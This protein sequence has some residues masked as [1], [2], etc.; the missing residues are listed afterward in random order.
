MADRYPL[1]ANP[2]SN[3]IEE[4]AA[5]DNLSL[6]GNSIVGASTITANQFIGNLAGSATTSTFLF[7]GANILSGTINP[8][9]LS[10]FYPIGVSTANVLNNATNILSGTVPRERLSGNYDI[11]ITGT[12]AT[13]NSLTSASN[14]TGGILPS[15]RLSGVYNIDITGTAYQAVGAAASLTINRQ[16]DNQVQFLTYTKNFDSDTS[17]FVNPEGLVYN[18]ALNYVGIGTSIP[19]ANLDVR[20]VLRNVGLTTTNNLFA[21][22]AKIPTLEGVTSIDATTRNTIE[23]SLGLDVLNDL[24]VVGLSTFDDTRVLNQTTLNR[25]NVTGVSTQVT[26]NITN[27]TATRAN[28]TGVTTVSSVSVG[29]TQ[30][31]SSARQLQNLTGIDSTTAAS[32]RADLGLNA[33]TSIN[34][35]GLSTFQDV[36]VAGITS[37]T[38]VNVSGGATFQTINAAT[39]LGSGSQLSGIVTTIIPGIG[40]TITPGNGK[41][42]VRIDA[43]KPIGK[44]IFVT[45]NGNDSNSGLTE[46]DSK[47]SIKAAAAIALPGDT[48]KVFPGYY[49]ENN[50]IILGKNVAVEGAELR[51]CQVRPLN[52]DKDLFHVNNAVHITDLSFVGPDS[53]NGAAVVAFQPLVGV[54]SNRFFDA[55]RL[56]RMNLDYIAGEAVGYLTSTAYKSPAFVVPTGNARDCSDDIKDIFKAI[57]YDITRGGNSKSVGAAKTYFNNTG[58]LQH[59]TGT[60]VNGYSVRQATID[61]IKYAVGIAFSCVNN[62]SWTGNHQS[63]VTQVKDLG[64]LPDPAT[65]SNKDIASCANVLSAVH[66]CAGIVTTIIGAGTTI[67]GVG[68]N[69]TYPGNAGA[70]S[71]IPN[72]PTFSPG[73]GPILQGP[74]IRN[75]TNFIPKSIGM[76]VDGFTAEPGDQDDVG[77]TGSMSVDSY[78]QYNQGGIGVS[79]TNGAYAQLVSIFTI[80]CDTAIY[81]ESGGQCDIT[82]SNSSFGNRGLVSIGVGDNSTKSIYTLTGA[83]TTTVTNG[84]NEIIISGIGSYRPYDGQVVYFDKLYYSVQEV[85]ITDGGSGYTAVP[86]VTI[87]TPTGPN[88]I[89]A[90]ASATVENGSVTSVTIVTAGSQYASAPN[91][92]IQSPDSG[93]TATA[94]VSRIDPIYYRVL[95]STLPSAGITTVTLAQNLNN[96]VSTGTTAYFSRLSLQLAS[97]HAFEFIGSG[98]EILKAKPALGGVTIQENEVV[99]LDGGDVVY[100]STDQAGNFRIGDGVTINQATGAVSG[101]DF[102]KALFTTM[103][104]FILALS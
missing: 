80:C 6:L 44:T 55:A 56:I 67:L 89:T 51:N 28:I 39:F 72:D 34:V 76:K 94:E 3:Q 42:S 7:S 58:A 95:E 21:L 37:L 22:V 14:I 4:L 40:V 47:A 88:G 18:P 2:T 26:A 19:L 35:T 49:A 65:G 27:L 33:L 16:T 98:T 103:T 48:I 97:S 36:T 73:V 82:N 50:P 17:A 20:G 54:S 41:G 99:K 83:A 85:R 101:R 77:V 81:T 45:Q 62:V 32:F 60:D 38:N 24:T 57:C 23:V 53:I 93:T 79:I 78:T 43:Y 10:G 104:P 59:I 87:D 15:A 69:T 12:A 1:I 84:Q 29:S 11:N 25:L 9:R 90:Q 31:L 13:S 5:N 100:T 8:D 66:T 102:T 63:Q 91:I 96:T 86:R 64:I 68:I 71:T 30:I 61:T 74:Y 52:P 70:G 92:T 46:N 75:C